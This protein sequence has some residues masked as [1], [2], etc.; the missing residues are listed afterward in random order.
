MEKSRLKEIYEI[1]KKVREQIQL[2]IGNKDLKGFC[3][4][5]SNKI[6]LLLRLKGYRTKLIKG[7]FMVESPDLVSIDPIYWGSEDTYYPPHYWVEIDNLI[8]DV[9]ADQFNV[10]LDVENHMDEIVI[11]TYEELPRYM[12]Y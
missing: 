11:G 8:I 1:A 5:C 2:E 9:T 10:E 7:R 12:P 6:R 3:K 4:Y